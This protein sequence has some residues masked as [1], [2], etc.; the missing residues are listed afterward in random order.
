MLFTYPL[1]VV[2]Q[3]I[4]ARIGRVTGQGIAGNLRQHYPN[5]ILQPIVVLLFVANTL[6]I[7]ADLG[8]MGEAVRLLVPHLPGWFWV[9]SFGLACTLSQLFLSHQQYVGVLKW[10]TLVLLSYFGVLAVIHV[11]W[12]VV[13]KSLIL[14]HWSLNSDSWL[15][16]VAILGTTIS[17][18]LFF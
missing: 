18:Y 6:N 14:P 9:I 16:V 1:M 12:K 15:M 5:W 7:G 3:D 10:L 4:S 17:P 13:L 11:P 8:A 2:V